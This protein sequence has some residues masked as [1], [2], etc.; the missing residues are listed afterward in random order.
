MM[1]VK[2]CTKLLAV[3]GP[4]VSSMTAQSSLIE[5][6]RSQARPSTPAVRREITHH[7]T[8]VTS[9]MPKQRKEGKYETHLLPGVLRSFVPNKIESSQHTLCLVMLTTGCTLQPIEFKVVAAVEN[10][11]CTLLFKL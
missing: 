3:T 1:P 6:R 7:K 11:P 8:E 9:T 10:A 2:F 4:D 5:G